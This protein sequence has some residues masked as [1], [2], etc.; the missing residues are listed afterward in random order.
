M[1]Q[2]SI[3]LILRIQEEKI[4]II[5]RL[6]TTTYLGK[7]RR[8]SIDLLAKASTSLASLLD[9]P[10]AIYLT[11]TLSNDLKFWKNDRNLRICRM[12]VGRDTSQEHPFH[13]TSFAANVERGCIPKHILLITKN[14]KKQ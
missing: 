2:K 7:I 10:M 13:I 12:K 6:S 9:S 11:V 8:H 14:C 3:T 1:S 5:H 4:I